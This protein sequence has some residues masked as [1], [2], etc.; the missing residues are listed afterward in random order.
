LNREFACSTA[1]PAVAPAGSGPDRGGRPPIAGGSQPWGDNR[2]VVVA[3]AK[4]A[5]DGAPIRFVQIDAVGGD[6]ITL[7]SA[8]LHSSVAAGECVTATRACCTLGTGRHLP[9]IPD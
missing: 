3:A 4:G 2:R 7:P 8:A 6:D 1:S 9:V 5:A